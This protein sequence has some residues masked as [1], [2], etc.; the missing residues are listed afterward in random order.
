MP[1][2]TTT[3]TSTAGVKMK[4]RFTSGRIGANVRAGSEPPRSPV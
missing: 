3:G 2:R 1:A 4:L